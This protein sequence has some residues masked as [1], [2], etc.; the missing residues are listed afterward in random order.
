[1]IH[2]GDEEN[3]VLGVPLCLSGAVG[4][5][6]QALTDVIWQ[7]FIGLR[8]PFEG[9]GAD[10]GAFFQQNVYRLPGS[11]AVDAA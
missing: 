1:M 2:V 9:V 6:A 11:L 8:A 3:I 4:C 5:K 7:S 10:N